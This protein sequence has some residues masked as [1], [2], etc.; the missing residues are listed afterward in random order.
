MHDENIL[1]MNRLKA[2]AVIKGLKSRNMHGYFAETKEEALKQALSL[3]PEKS[4]VGYGGSVSIDQ[5]GLK[6]AL[7]DGDYK[8]IKREEAK[9]KAEQHDKYREIFDADFFLASANAM[10]EDGIIV[11]IDG[12]S[13][14]VSALA[15]GPEKVLY[16][17]GMNKVAKDLDAAVLRARNIAAPANAQRFD[18]DT[19]CK[20]AGSCFN[21]KSKDCICSNVLITR[22]QAD[23]E[24]IHVILVNEDLGF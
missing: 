24:R 20:A 10:T 5:I 7:D 15:F 22:F 17:V 16:I 14:R 6:K 4:S 19:P 3:I 2:Q 18:I 8:L 1:K 23:P 21:C 9:T 13:N 12:N 11:N